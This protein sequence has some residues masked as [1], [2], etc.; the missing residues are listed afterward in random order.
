ME[1]ANVEK[2]YGYARSK[3][4][5]Q[6]P[7]DSATPPKPDNSILVDSRQ[8][9]ALTAEAATRAAAWAVLTAKAAPHAVCGLH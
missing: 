3:D 2:H 8:V 5:L 4:G 6:S 1:L 7:R 9:I